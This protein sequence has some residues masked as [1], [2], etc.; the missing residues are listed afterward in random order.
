[1]SKYVEGLNDQIVQRYKDSMEIIVIERFPMGD[2]LLLELFSC[3]AVPYFE[4]KLLS[5]LEPPRI[6]KSDVVPT[7]LRPLFLEQ[8]TNEEKE[9]RRQ[10]WEQVRKVMARIR[11][12]S[13]PE[14]FEINTNFRCIP[15]NPIDMEAVER[16]Y[17][18][19]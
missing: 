9:L 18:N 6:N 7:Y 11:D 1:M 3:E 10:L 15:K 16:R 5:F 14:K 8:L 4:N 13:D 17:K 19:E 12:F 2:N